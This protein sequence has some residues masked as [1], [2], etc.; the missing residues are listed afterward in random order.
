ML[1]SPSDSR[2][3]FRFQRRQFPLIISYA[4]TI[5]KSQ[6]QSLS[7]VGLLLKKHVL[8]TVGCMLQFQE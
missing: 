7:H 4:M 3:P 5:N 6:G 8:V 2:L 1:L